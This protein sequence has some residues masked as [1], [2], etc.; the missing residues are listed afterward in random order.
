[1]NVANFE[2]RRLFG[3]YQRSLRRDHSPIN[4]HIERAR[5]VAP[6]IKASL[7]IVAWFAI[8]AFSFQSSQA[9]FESKSLSFLT[10]P[11]AHT[12]SQSASSAPRPKESKTVPTGTDKQETTRH[13][14]AGTILPATDA[15]SATKPSHAAQFT[16]RGYAFGHCTYYVAKRRPLP[17]NWGNARDW[18][19]RAQAAGFTTGEYARPGAIGQTPYGPYGHVVYVE[20]VDGDRVYVSEMNYVG[21]NVKSYRWADESEFKYIY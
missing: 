17:Q 5:G 2:Q 6:A 13:A 10:N 1:M 4:A 7:T 16:S 12:T 15:P 20:Q 21:W 19:R 8:F 14:E 11:N 3:A 18:V 9:E